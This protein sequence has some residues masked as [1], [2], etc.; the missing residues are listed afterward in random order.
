MERP[1]DAPI[2]GVRGRTSPDKRRLPRLEERP[3]DRRSQL[4]VRVLKRALIVFG[5]GHCTMRCQ[6]LDVSDAGAMVRPNDILL[7]PN[8][9]LL[10]PEIG[11]PRYCEVVW[12]SNAMLG[13]RYV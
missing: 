7:C 13:V 2:N 1:T 3:D 10:K 6:I 8:E 9:F 11:A 5:N 12:R 4:R